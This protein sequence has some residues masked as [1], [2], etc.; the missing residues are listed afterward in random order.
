MNIRLVLEYNGTGF[1][2]WQKQPDLRTVQG[3]LESALHTVLRQEPRGLTASGRT[4]AGVHALRQVAH[5]HV[6]GEVKLQTLTRGVS[7]LLKNEVS[8]LRAEIVDEGF[9]SIRD[10]LRKCYLYRIH[11]APTPPVLEYGRVSH[12]SGALDQERLMREMELIEGEHDF[13]SFRASGCAAKTPVRKIESARLMQEGDLL[14][15]EFIGNGFLK[16]MV[17]NLVGTL[18]ELSL[19]GGHEERSMETILAEG[20]RRKAG[21][22]AEPWGL[23]LAWVEYPEGRL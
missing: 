2:G 19:V 13:T 17:R 21:P 12:V 15:L 16:Q 14:T 7:S 23:H 1:H 8:I 4:D 10:S 22:T 18:I 11:N 20:D 3:E 6:D 5:F 9:H